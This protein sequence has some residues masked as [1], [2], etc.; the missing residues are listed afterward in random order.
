MAKTRWFLTA[1]FCKQGRRGVFC[2]SGGQPCVSDAQHTEDEMDEAFGPF[3]VLMNAQSV[4]LG[5]AE[6]AK[7]TRWEPLAE[8]SNVWGLAY[9]AEQ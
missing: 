8:Y 6:L 5:E 4:E 2:N 7:Y 1:D 3:V 9:K